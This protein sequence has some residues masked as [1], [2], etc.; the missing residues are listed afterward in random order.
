VRRPD[1]DEGSDRSGDF[2]EH[3]SRGGRRAWRD[4]LI[5]AA[6][7]LGHI[8][9]KQWAKQLESIDQVVGKCAVLRDT[10][11][12][13]PRMKVWADIKSAKADGREIR[14][15]GATIFSCAPI[16]RLAAASEDRFRPA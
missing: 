12:R 9:Y 6:E 5:A 15:E 13:N 11:R 2:G 1:T 4:R 16:A 3:F 7:E 14:D 8:P 10:G